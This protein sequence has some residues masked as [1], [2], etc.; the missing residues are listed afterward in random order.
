MRVLKYLCLNDF[1]IISIDHVIELWQLT[2]VYQLERLKY[3]CIG[4]SERGLCE[5]NLPHMLQDAEN[6]IC[7]CEV[8]KGDVSCFTCHIDDVYEMSSS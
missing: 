2:D 6:L 4:S 3:A 5:E 7:L 8:L 1:S